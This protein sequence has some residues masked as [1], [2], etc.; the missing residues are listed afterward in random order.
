MR[1]TRWAAGSVAVTTG[2]T[3]A[4]QTSLVCDVKFGAS[5]SHL[6]Q[7]GAIWS[8]SGAIWSDLERLSILFLVFEAIL[9]MLE[10]F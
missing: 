4:M 2:A 7:F 10:I 5:W 9:S 3:S 8:K 6:E 1:H